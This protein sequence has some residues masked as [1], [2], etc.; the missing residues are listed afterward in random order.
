[1]TGRSPR[2]YVAILPD[3]RRRWFHTV[4]G[5]LAW[6]AANAPTGGVL[7]AARTVAP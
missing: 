2:P 5:A 4:A 7:V 3:G 1:V 6:G